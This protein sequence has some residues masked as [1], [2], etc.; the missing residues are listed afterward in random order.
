MAFII[1]FLLFLSLPLL[2]DVQS[3]IE[4]GKNNPINHAFETCEKSRAVKT[5]DEFISTV[6]NLEALGYCSLVARPGEAP[7]ED[8]D[9]L[10]RD[11]NGF[12]CE[13][14][15][16][17]VM[18]SKCQFVH[19]ASDDIKQT[20]E[21]VQIDCSYKNAENL[22]LEAH[23]GDC[24]PLS[25]E[26]DCQ[27]FLVVKYAETIKA[28]EITEAYTPARMEKVRI[29]FER[30]KTK[31]L[32]KVRKSTLIAPDK[33][34]IIISRIAETQ[35]DLPPSNTEC[36]NTS[37]SGPESGIYYAHDDNKVHVCIGFMATLNHENDLDLMHTF[38]HEISHSIDP[39]T[40]ADVF[41]SEPEAG[42]S[43]YGGLIA[44]LRGGAGQDGCTNSVL[45]CNTERGHQAA[46]TE[47]A[48]SRD[49]VNPTNLQSFMDKCLVQIKRYDAC[50]ID[51]SPDNPSLDL[52]SYRSE[53]ENISQIRESFS[54]Y[55]GS[56]VVSDIVKEDTDSGKLTRS[57]RLDGITSLATTYAGLHGRCI[58]SNT[59]D[60]HPAPFLRMNRI[61]M[62]SESFRESLGCEG[63]P[64][65]TPGANM[66]CQ[67]L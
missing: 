1:P 23:K 64:P 30:V 59:K 5:V 55:M 62:G 32:E 46:C 43:V 22:F 66:K 54:D 51:A 26:R 10:C 12:V 14:K 7:Q 24:P 18:N 33:L 38:G 19:L 49:E 48:K 11:P 2:A 16:G 56:E 52:S 44:C 13:K 35:L 6:K 15:Q 45:N 60:S 8:M 28:M 3:C 57:D 39:C 61:I 20:A 21:F 29:A 17:Y 25:N 4:N 36:A 27:G 41:T 42:I 37:A 50:P 58:S 40:L 65:K 9:H 34:P 67:G 31:Y 47:S 63:G 53:G